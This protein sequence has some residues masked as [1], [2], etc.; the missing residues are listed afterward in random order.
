M[1]DATVK[2]LVKLGGGGAAMKVGGSG[3]SVRE[4]GSI[5]DNGVSAPRLSSRNVVDAGY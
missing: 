5:G 1:D 4:E 3:P 2:R